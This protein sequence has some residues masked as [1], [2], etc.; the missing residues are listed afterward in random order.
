MNMIGSDIDRA[1]SI[2]SVGADFPYHLLDS[3]ALAFDETNGTVLK[4]SRLRFQKCG[5]GWYAQHSRHYLRAAAIRTA[6]I[7]MQPGSVA[8]EGNQIRQRK[9]IVVEVPHR[10]LPIKALPYGRASAPCRRLS[11]SS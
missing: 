1:Q 8:P 7:A 11:I 2:L 4:L 9:F 10:R 3:H 5:S 6:F